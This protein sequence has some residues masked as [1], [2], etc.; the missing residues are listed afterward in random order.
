MLISH[1]KVSNVDGVALNGFLGKKEKHLC[2]VLSV[3]QPIG[4]NPESDLGDRKA[5]KG[6][7]LLILL[8]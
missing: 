8:S 4:T 3:G 2:N 5:T 1:V 6:R 7:F